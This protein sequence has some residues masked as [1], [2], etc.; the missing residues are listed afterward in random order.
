MGYFGGTIKVSRGPWFREFWVEDDGLDWFYSFLDND[1]NKCY[2]LSNNLPLQ[3]RERLAYLYHSHV[4]NNR[5]SWFLGGW[6]GFEAVTKLQYCRSSALGWR[7]FQWFGLSFLIKSALVGYSAQHYN[8]I[9]GAFFRKYSSQVKKDIFEI[10]DEK[11]QYFYIDTSQYMNYTNNELSD[12]Y[13]V[14]HGPQ[15]VSQFVLV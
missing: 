14:H 2:L 6:L 7:F 8:P 4:R 12:E 15:P 10:R 11:K 5:I 9:V 1:G 13:H 3:D